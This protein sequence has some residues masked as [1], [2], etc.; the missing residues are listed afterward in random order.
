MEQLSPCTITTEAHVPRACA[1]PQEKPLQWEVC[2][3]Q[4]D[5]SPCSLHLEKALVQQQRPMAAKN[6]INNKERLPGK[7]RSRGWNARWT[8]CTNHTLQQ[9][10]ARSEGTPPSV[11]KAPWWLQQSCQRT[12]QR[13]SLTK[14]QRNLQ[15]RTAKG[16]RRQSKCSDSRTPRG[17]WEAGDRNPGIKYQSR[18][19][20]TLT[21]PLES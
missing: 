3:W 10:C 1:P 12:S 13:K 20:T 16:D 2:P 11:L 9:D 19:K 15:P 4:L 14:P 7:E 5:S 8:A 18:R 21:T 6:K 17:M